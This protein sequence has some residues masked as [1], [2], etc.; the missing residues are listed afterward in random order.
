MCEEKT[1][2]QLSYYQNYKFESKN[3]VKTKITT[4]IL[5]KK[6][7]VNVSKKRNYRLHIFLLFKYCT[8]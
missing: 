7:N 5:F 8:F 1:L 6:V 4:T 2:L 3:Q